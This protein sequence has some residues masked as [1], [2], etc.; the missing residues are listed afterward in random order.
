MEEKF[1]IDVIDASYVNV[2]FVF[3]NIAWGLWR[4]EANENEKNDDMKERKRGDK[5]CS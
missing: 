2:A 4:N 1:S 5:N 3:W